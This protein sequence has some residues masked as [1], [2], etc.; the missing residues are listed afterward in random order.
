MIQTNLCARFKGAFIV[1]CWVFRNNGLQRKR[2]KKTAVAEMVF[3]LEVVPE[4]MR[5]SVLMCF[6]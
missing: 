1:D 2:L 4:I 5:K 3:Y 6:E